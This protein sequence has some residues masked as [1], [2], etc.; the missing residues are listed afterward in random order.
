MTLVEVKDKQTYLNKNYPI[1][2]EVPKVTDRMF[3]KRCEEWFTVKDYVVVR[4]NNF[5]F[6]YHTKECE[7]SPLM[8]T[9]NSETPDTFNHS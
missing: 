2:G 3:C 5:D 1:A 6:I 9:N 4:E 7:S 8:W